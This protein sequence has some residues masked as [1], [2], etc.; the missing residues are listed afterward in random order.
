MGL[1]K[2]IEA[3]I[4]DHIKAHVE[5]LDQPAAP[6]VAISVTKDGNEIFTGC[7][8]LAEIN[9]PVPVARDTV[10]RIGSQTK[11]F[12]VLLILM[13][14]ADGKLSLED[15]L[16]DHLPWLPE[17]AEP[18]KLVHLAANMSGFRD[19]LEAMAFSGRSIF[20]PS[21]RQTARDALA[22]QDAL[23][24]EPGSAMIYSNSGFLLLSD[25]IEKLEDACFD[26]VL[27]RRIT[28]PL[29]MSDTHLMVRDGEARER[30]AAHYTLQDGNW[31]QAAW[32]VPLGGEGGMISTLNDMCL[33]QRALESGDMPWASLW[34]RMETPAVYRNR[35]TAP[36]GLGLVVGDYRGRLAI[37][38]GG[39][40][41]GGRSES[42]RFPDDG[43][44]IVIQA[45]HDQIA[46]FSLARRIA[47][48]VFGDTP[49]V[50]DIPA[51]AG[52]YRQENGNGVFE[53][54][55][56]DEGSFL[57][58]PDGELPLLAEPD[59]RFKPE[60]GIAD[61]LLSPRPDGSL[62]GLWCGEPRRFR[63]LEPCK[64]DRSLSGRYVN[65]AQGIDAIIE[66]ETGHAQLRLRSNLGVLDGSIEPL[67]RDIW[68]MRPDGQ[69][70]DGG[71]DWTATLTA[72][73]SGFV[74][75]SERT[76]GLAFEKQ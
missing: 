49:P 22:R 63:K 44:G 52:F 25:I 56:R 70:P 74:L 48:V 71:S 51:A 54:I 64:A 1:A 3:Q 41:A 57:R 32:G 5:G 65:R 50:A 58:S 4:E 42:M 39:S 38:H 62:D 28:G 33:W 31:R 40:V 12:T 6:G 55:K 66:G 69:H 36:Y 43:L 29:G 8:G 9:H 27:K 59:G 26:E 37:G 68:L 18:V 45:N 2:D 24:F 10:M 7:Y 14:E 13:L 53:I 61:L 15:A 72:T 47:D 17:V 23:N 67:D 76:R 11:Q 30:L 35:E 75:D 16:C 60:R 21:E 73:S 20:S 46:T 19:F 34:R